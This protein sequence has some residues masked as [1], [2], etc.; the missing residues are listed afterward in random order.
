LASFGD[1]GS[2]KPN[3]HEP[4]EGGTLKN[5]FSSM[6]KRVIISR[7]SARSPG[8]HQIWTRAIANTTVISNFAGINQLDLLRRLFGSLYISTEVY[9][10]I[11]VGI[12]E[13][14][15]FYT[16]ID[17]MTY[18]FVHDGRIR[19]TSM[20]EDVELGSYGELPSRLHWGEASCLVV[21]RHRGWLLLTDDRAARDKGDRLGIMVE[22]SWLKMPCL[23]G[24]KRDYG[25]MRNKQAQPSSQ[26]VK[27]AWL[28]VPLWL[29]INP[30]C[31]SLRAIHALF[32][33][34]NVRKNWRSTA[35][36]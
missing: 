24:K 28:E 35:S 30:S 9:E 6:K 5:P 12:E 19:L 18:P 2:L 26:P 33:P 25:K 21:A 7:L 29:A 4:V 8:I 32:P 34:R 15:Q 23:P 1:S 31:I 36:A 13:G 20:A 17:Q 14:Y 11:Q 10:E 27:V 16:G 22:N 3:H